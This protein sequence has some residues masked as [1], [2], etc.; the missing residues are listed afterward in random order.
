MVPH[1]L[2]GVGTT[3][4]EGLKALSRFDSQDGLVDIS[5]ILPRAVTSLKAGD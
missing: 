5:R 2:W 4:Q 1:V 3:P